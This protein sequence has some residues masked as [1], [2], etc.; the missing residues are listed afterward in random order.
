MSKSPPPSLPSSIPA[1]LGFEQLVH[2]HG[3]M[4]NQKAG[5]DDIV[6]YLTTHF[7]GGIRV[8]H[9]EDNDLIT[10]HQV[11]PFKVPAPF[12]SAKVI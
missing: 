5:K 12:L 10:S 11:P 7:L 3:E 1:P 8:N 9:S 6:L 2:S 4:G